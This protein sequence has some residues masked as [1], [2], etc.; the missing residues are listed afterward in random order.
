[1]LAE[2]FDEA[3]RPVGLKG[4]QFTLLVAIRL[5]GA[6]R[7]GSLA[8]ILGMDRT[9][10][11]RNLRPLERDGLVESARGEDRRERRLRLTP[12]GEERLREAHEHWARA[13]TWIV[14]SLGEDAWTELMERVRAVHAMSE[15]GAPR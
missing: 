11:S 6:P 3:L 8:G 2:V 4:T 9:T 5:A 1:M 13:Q 12:A 7:L 15:E 10:L 14:E